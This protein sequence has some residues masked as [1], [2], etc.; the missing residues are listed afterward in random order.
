M[1]SFIQCEH[2]GFKLTS[3]MKDAITNGKCPACG[4]VLNLTDALGVLEFI[5]FSVAE[6]LPLSAEH[7]QKY[8]ANYFIAKLG[9]TVPS[10]ILEEEMS[11]KIRLAATRPQ[12][13]IN[14]EVPQIENEVPVEDESPIAP[15]TPKLARGVTLTKEELA[16]VKK[17]LGV[18][19]IAMA[20]NPNKVDSQMSATHDGD[21]SIKFIALTKE[22]KHTIIHGLEKPAFSDTTEE[23]PI[24]SNDLIAPPTEA[25]DPELS[26]MER[27]VRLVAQMPKLTKPRNSI[28]V[29]KSAVST[30]N[31]EL[32]KDS[33]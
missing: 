24:L 31:S 25:E 17:G 8:I 6:K 4:G 22:Q 16:E 18:M 14:L 15:P 30:P 10:I 13:T 9:M 3:E 27:P 5:D 23:E 29:D 1:K 2:C 12:T 19:P 28:F 11:D 21:K 20:G 32:Q 33:L 26:G 7:F